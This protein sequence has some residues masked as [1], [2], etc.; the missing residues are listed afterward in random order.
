MI[1]VVCFTVLT[2]W[3]MAATPALAD[4]RLIAESRHPTAKERRAGRAKI[5]KDLERD[6]FRPLPRIVGGR[7]AADGEYPWMVGL[8][9]AGEPD[10]Y[11][12]L[13]CG[14]SLIH[15]YWV[16]TAAHCVLGSRAEDIEV[17]VGANDLSNPGSG[18]QRIAVSEIIIS[19][20]YNDS[21]MDAD[22]ALLRLAEPA[23][24]TAIPVID[25][26]DHELPGVEATVTGWGTTTEGTASYP[27]RL[28]EV[29]LPIVDLELANESPAYDGTLTGNM[30]AAGFEEGGKDACQGD[31][32]SPLIVPSPRAP[33]WMQAGVVSFGEGCA[34]PD[35]YG[36]YTRIGNFRDFITGHI[37]PNYAAWERANGR[38]GENIDLDEDGRTNFEEWALPDGGLELQMAAGKLW[39][40]Y[41]RPALASEADY[42]LEHA[43]SAAGPWSAVTGAAMA[44]DEVLEGGGIL[45]TFELPGSA[46]TGVYRVR[47]AFSATYVPGPRPLAVPGGATGTL[48][49]PD[50]VQ[51]GRFQKSYVLQ[52]PDGTGPLR[53]AVR[54]GDFDT[55]FRLSGMSSPAVIEV[56]NNAGKGVLGGDELYDFTP[57]AGR[58]YRVEV[59]SHDPGATGS[60]E[61]NVWRPSVIAALPPLAAAGGVVNG[62]LS[63]GD[64]FDPF[65]LPGG[66]FY[67]DDYRI[68][69]SVFSPG[70]LIELRMTSKGKA[71]KAIDDSIILIDAESGR[72]ITGNDNF[73]GKTNDSG[74]RFQPVTGKSYLLRASASEDRDVGIYR[75]TSSRIDPASK[76]SPVPT[77]NIGASVKG[78]LAAASELDER[79]LTFKRDYLLAPVSGDRKVVVTLSSAKF[80]AYLMVLDPRD[81]SVVEEGDSGG[82]S[83]GRDNAKVEFTARAGRRYFIRATSYDPRETGPFVLTT[84]AAP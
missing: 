71:T 28:Q 45:R 84:T 42:Y 48:A 52:I 61:L 9:D 68:D 73:T 57:E 25:D 66:E 44:E 14:A 46:N 51:D 35:A 74:L 21:T 11:D 39:L 69:T 63:T 23:S 18:A 24:G 29:E 56:D 20:T 47:A 30:L 1:R 8:I 4:K 58:E 72:L 2:L 13:F 32:G 78:K 17:L 34:Q 43:S 37:R 67:K 36:I 12:G 16:L 80:D 79:Y 60:F 40:S 7:A 49:N 82:P 26:R 59:T 70:G 5:E 54:S 27:N 53:I 31:S 3:G 38:S 55:R 15:P 81:L 64:A 19:P 10:E 6:G 62:S 77:V 33:G 41:V 83:G 76:K 22:F 65:F 50:E 75:L